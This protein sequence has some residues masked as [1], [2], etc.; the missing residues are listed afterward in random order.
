M[1]FEVIL[2][3]DALSALFSLARSESLL[4]VADL[5]T[6]GVR[7]HIGEDVMIDL[8]DV[9]FS[10]SRLLPLA[11]C[12]LFRRLIYSRFYLQCLLDLGHLGRYLE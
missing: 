11:A 9:A 5:R 10:I 4:R 12:I 3:F 8:A 7:F 1:R 2:L 6:S